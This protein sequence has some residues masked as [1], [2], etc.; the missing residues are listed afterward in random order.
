MYKH[1]ITVVG[2]C[3][4]GVRVIGYIAV[5][6]STR[7]RLYFNKEQFQGLVINK[8]VTNCTGQVYGNKIIIKG[9]NCQ[10]TKLPK[11]DVNGNQIKSENANE[12]ETNKMVI[13]GKITDSKEVVG[14]RLKYLSNGQLK[15]KDVPRKIVLELARDKKIKNARV[16]MFNNRLL[17]RGVDCDL[18]KLPSVQGITS[19]V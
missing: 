18:S 6:N 2:R 19:L 9:V 5:D 1:G 4:D 17:L 16:Q 15:Y 12:K 7:A 11:F 3:M 14:Y 10:L 13:I 8:Q